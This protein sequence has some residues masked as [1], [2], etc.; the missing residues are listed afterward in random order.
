M[1]VLT[2]RHLLLVTLLVLLLKGSMAFFCL[3]AKIH[4]AQHGDWIAAL[5]V[6]VPDFDFGQESAHCHDVGALAVPSWHPFHA[7]G[8]CAQ[9]HFVMNVQI[10]LLMLVDVDLQ[11]AVVALSSSC[12][13]D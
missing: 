1:R 8:V 9:D 11:I 12:H 13:D 5:R 6:E 2:L 3:L 4:R 10:A 7:E